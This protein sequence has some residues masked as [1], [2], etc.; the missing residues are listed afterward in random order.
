DRAI[1]ADERDRI[2]AVLE[3]VKAIGGDYHRLRTRAAG[4]K[5]FVDVHI[6]VPGSMTVHDGHDLA[7]RL[8]QEIE[9]A[10]PHVEVLTHLES[11]EDPRSW[12]HPAEP[13]PPP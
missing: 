11:L 5:S 1:P 3:Q 2:V 6:L 13:A 8:E 4:K 10:M 12:D 7:H 9:T